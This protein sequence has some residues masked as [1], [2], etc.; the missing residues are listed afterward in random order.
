MTSA[1]PPM[2]SPTGGKSPDWCDNCR[3]RRPSQ[4]DQCPARLAPQGASEAAAEPALGE[5]REPWSAPGELPS[6]ISPSLGTEA[7]RAADAPLPPPIDVDASDGTATQLPGLV[8]D[9]TDALSP[10]GTLTT[11]GHVR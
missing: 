1:P 2:E 11:G 5:E 10:P 8:D 3:F 7:P 9:D 6:S 4:C